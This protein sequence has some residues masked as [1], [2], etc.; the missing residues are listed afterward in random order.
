MK[1]NAI[2]PAQMRL[3]TLLGSR[4]SQIVGAQLDAVHGIQS[5]SQY[6]AV[7]QGPSAPH[8]A[9]VG[10]FPIHQFPELDVTVIGTGEIGDKARQLIFKTAWLHSIG[11]HTSPKHILTEGFIDQFFLHN[12]WGNGLRDARPPLPRGE[13]M[14]RRLR[15]KKPDLEGDRKALRK[16]I[17]EGKF[18][19]EQTAVLQHIITASNATPLV[20]RSSAMGDARGTG[21]YKSVFMVYRRDESNTDSL[22]NSIRKVL[23]SYFSEAAF[24]LQTQGNAGQG[25]GIILEP[26]IGQQI[27]AGYDDTLAPVLSG[28][29]YT[30]TAKGPGFIKV[31]PGLG[32]GVQSRDAWKI[33]RKDLVPHGGILGKYIKHQVEHIRRTCEVIPDI[34]LFRF[35]EGYRHDS[36]YA[37]IYDRGEVYSSFEYKDH[38]NAAIKNL[39][40]LTLFEMMDEIE[41]RIGSFQYFEWALTFDDDGNPQW[42]ITQIAD[43][44]PTSDVIEFLDSSKALLL[45][46]DVEGSGVK[47]GRKIVECTRVSELS[48][49]EK[50]N[51]KNEDYVLVYSANLSTRVP[52]DR[53]IFSSTPRRI[54]ASDFSN[55]A[56]AIEIPDVAH[57]NDPASHFAGQLKELGI[58]FGVLAPE[59]E[60]EIP[61]HILKEHEQLVGGLKLWDVPFRVISSEHRDDLVV[62]LAR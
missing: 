9:A 19:D 51:Q 54:Q 29:G 13:R 47:T 28:C 42:W 17:S 22:S 60:M 45:V 20:V 49:L 33:F 38:I 56:A 41:R 7:D 30:S 34:A 12:G 11:F 37:Q 50:F 36:Y 10:G 31:V 32:G 40:I 3:L 14:W 39:N 4:A 46:H 43:A 53:P 57:V 58:L 8:L 61:W 23:A 26:I 1:G 24:L 52:R 21:S 15:F 6:I 18:T 5:S 44:N 62:Y 55:A 35:R 48:D 25:M 16:L 2:N 59:T 27:E